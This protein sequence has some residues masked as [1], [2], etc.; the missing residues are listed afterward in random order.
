MITIDVLVTRVDGLQRADL[1]QWVASDWVRAETV[2][3]VLSFG[4]IDVARVTL[5]HALRSDLEVNDAT[6]PIVL[7]LLDQLYDLRRQVRQLSEVIQETVPSEILAD[8]SH[9]LAAQ[10]L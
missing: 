1:E 6:L 3:D 9:R 4:D 5:I 10:T 8:I 2:G 7:S